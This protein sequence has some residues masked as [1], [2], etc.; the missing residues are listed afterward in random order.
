MDGVAA[1]LGHAD[2]GDGSGPPSRGGSRRVQQVGRGV[3]PADRPLRVWAP[4]AGRGP[5]PLGLLPG[6]ARSRPRVADA[7]HPSVGAASSP[8]TISRSCWLWR[9]CG[10]SRA[11]IH[12]TMHRG[13]Q[14]GRSRLFPTAFVFSMVYPSAIFLANIGL[15]VRARRG[16]PRRV[17]RVARGDCGADPTEWLRGGDRVDDRRR[18]C[19]FPA[20]VARCTGGRTRVRGARRVVRAVLALDR[21]PHR[22]PHCE[23]RYGTSWTSSTSDAI[24]SRMP[25]HICTSRWGSRR[26][27]SCCSGGD[28]CRDPG[29]CSAGSISSRH[30]DSGSSVWAGTRMSASRRSSPPASFSSAPVRRLDSR[31]FLIAV[32]LQAA[33]AWWILHQAHVP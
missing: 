32:G 14:S 21:K 7:R 28:G 3:V 10:A 31:L 18:R 15:G 26:V 11:A 20:L 19:G 12:R 25:T 24:R 2:R 30:S 8:S 16:T 29:R 9:A 13:S 23:T 33:G 27:L 4:S 22:L 6:A 5:D 17:G 1:D